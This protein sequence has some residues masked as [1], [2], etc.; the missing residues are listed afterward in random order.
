MV[1]SPLRGTLLNMLIKNLTCQLM[2]NRTLYRH[3]TP[4][5]WINSG[6]LTIKPI[7]TPWGIWNKVIKLGWVTFP[8]G[9]CLEKR[10]NSSLDRR[11]WVLCI[12]WV[13]V[14]DAYDPGHIAYN[15]SPFRWLKEKATMSCLHWSQVCPTMPL[16]CRRRPLPQSAMCWSSRLVM[17]MEQRVHIPCFSPRSD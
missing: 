14:L 1:F 2:F 10:G 13:P 9:L 11:D 7:F 17:V 3:L 12:D 6:C 4:I 16:W 15:L 5:G 8:M